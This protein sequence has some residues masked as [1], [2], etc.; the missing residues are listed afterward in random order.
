MQKTVTSLKLNVRRPH[1]VDVYLDGVP[2]M[3][4]MKSIALT[5]SVGQVFAPEEIEDVKQRSYEEK[6]YQQAV[7]LVSRRPRS[8][9]EIRDR[10]MRKNVPNETQEVVISRLHEARLLDDTA[11]ARSWVENRNTFRPRSAWA[12]KIEL[13]KKGVSSERIDE[14]LE[15]F[16]DEAAAFQAASVGARKYRNLDRELFRKRLGAYLARRGFQYHLISPAVEL[17]LQE[18]AGNEQE[19]EVTK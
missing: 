12:I 1:L 5:L 13:M 15:N 10:L 16:D 2:E 3:R 4:V 14:V 8:E 7:G 6:M 18:H 17:E 19:S 11:F 9:R